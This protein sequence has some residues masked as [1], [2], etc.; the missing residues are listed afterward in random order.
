MEAADYRAGRAVAA[1]AAEHIAEPLE[2][3]GP[4][5]AA[6]PGPLAVGAV[7]T[8]VVPEEQALAGMKVV[9]TAEAGEHNR[10]AAAAALAAVWG[11]GVGPRTLESLSFR[12]PPR[13]AQSI[14]AS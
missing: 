5:I 10:P 8:A 7:D 13:P 14:S 1:W 6:A 11:Q 4:G 12:V 2:A 3:A 9:H